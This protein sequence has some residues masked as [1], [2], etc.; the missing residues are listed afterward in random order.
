V[1]L[2]SELLHIA[3]RCKVCNSRVEM[4]CQMG[5]GFCCQ[6]CEQEYAKKTRPRK[7]IAK[8]SLRT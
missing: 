6:N 2:V 4:I 5:T 1:E 3:E 7:G 8:L